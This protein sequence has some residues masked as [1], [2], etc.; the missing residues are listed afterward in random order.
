MLHAVANR[1]THLFTVSE[2]SKQNIIKHLRVEADK[3]TVIYNGIGS[4]FGPGDT[5][6]ARENVARRF[7]IS[8]P[9]LLYVGSLKPHKNIAVLV[10]AYAQLEAGK[11]PG[12]QLVIAGTGQTVKLRLEQ[13]A[14]RLAV[15]PLFISDADDCELTQLYRAAEVLVLPSFEEGFGLPILE[16]MACGTPVACAN[17]AAMPEVAGDA[18]MFFD[19][20]DSQDL[21]R[22]LRMLLSSA[23]LRQSLRERGLTRAKQFTWRETAAKHIPIYQRYLS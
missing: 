11:R 22:I 12:V 20:H 14:G 3:I 9:Y 7:G 18:A 17:A 1:A 19:P 5:E 21:C 13:Q 10:A 23:D 16:A 4:Q 2:Y 8:Q 6:L 15:R